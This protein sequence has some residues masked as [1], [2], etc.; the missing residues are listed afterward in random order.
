MS[1]NVRP[2]TFICAAFA[3][4]ISLAIIVPS[5]LSTTAAQAQTASPA[6]ATVRVDVTSGHEINSFDPDSA[7]G[8][9]I[10]VLS[11]NDID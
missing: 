9:S 10:D 11:H 5:L 6:V 8:S 1:R 3:N 4:T 2:N 7:L